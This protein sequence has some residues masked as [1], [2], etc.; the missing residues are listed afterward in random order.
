MKRTALI[1]ALIGALALGGC[2]SQRSLPE[3]PQAEVPQPTAGPTTLQ[4]PFTATVEGMNVGGQ[5]RWQRDSVVWVSASKL[6]ELGRAR[7]TRDSLLA[8]IPPYNQ[9]VRMDM[10]TVRRQFGLDFDS[11]QR[12]LLSYPAPITFKHPSLSAPVRVSFPSPGTADQ[13]LSFP[14]T[15]PPSAKP[16]KL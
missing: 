1:V 3:G 7:I 6:I 5:V 15:I 8:Y 12:V 10:A 16:L 14:L 11:L 2:R 4:R 9:Y 13:P